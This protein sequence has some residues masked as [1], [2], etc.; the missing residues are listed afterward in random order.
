MNETSLLQDESESGG[1][2]F[3]HVGRCTYLRI[4]LD[5][6]TRNVEYI[7]AR[8]AQ[9]TGIIAV[10]K[11]AAYG[12]GSQVV[13]KHLRAIGVERLAVATAGEGA[14]LRKANIAGPIHVFGN[15]HPIEA[16]DLLTHDLI[17]TV[18]SRDF[19]KQWSKLL[20][21]ESC[22]CR[23]NSVRDS[24]KGTGIIENGLGHVFDVCC[25]GK[26]AI[27][28]DTG[29]SRNGIKPKDLDD[30]VELCDEEGVEVD[31][32]FT[33]FSKSA[34]DHS[35]T[36]EQL[37]KF[38]KV[39]APYRSRGVKLH[40]ANSGAVLNGYGTDLDFV[41]PGLALYGLMSSHDLKNVDGPTDLEVQGGDIG[42][43][44]AL[45]WLAKPTLVK[46]L[47]P[48]RIIGYNNTYRTEK[49]EV[50]ATISVGYG[51]GFSR[52][53]SNNGYVKI[54]DGH[55]YPV[56][57]VVSMDAITVRTDSLDDVNKTFYLMSDDFDANTSIFARARQLGTVTYNIL[58]DLSVRIPRVYFRDGKLHSI[59]KDITDMY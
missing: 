28:V 49:E 19:I 1:D 51:D 59:V 12:H 4:N 7:R 24:D 25:H 23:R 29:M 8:C 47:M 33:H 31:S 36:H 46:T 35:W 20:K 15:A 30:F 58:T 43:Q 16:K 11:T 38:L 2:V 26:V 41:R 6:I 14:L 21:K 17:P 42:L 34:N 54:Q 53:F 22:R 55:H 40:V 52:G 45:A 44:P 3:A 39:A 57:G 32:I 37:E 27:K 9:H 5:A 56:V 13:G 50:I 48:G 18:S 10:I